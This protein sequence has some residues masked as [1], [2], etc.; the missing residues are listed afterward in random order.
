MRIKVDL[1]LCQGH[2]VCMEE[3]PEVFVVRDQPGGYPQVVVLMEQP[4][5]DLREKVMNAARGCPN[6]VITI[7]E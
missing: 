1:D 2:S 3:C 4:S 6:R 5:E 7:E